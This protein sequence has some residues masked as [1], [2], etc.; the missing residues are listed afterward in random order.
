M[1]LF[2]ALAAAAAVPKPTELKLYKDWAV[3]CD[4]GLF[5]HAVGLMPDG[6]PEDAI[7]MAV[8][9]GAEPDARPVIQFVFETGQAAAL[10]ADGQRLNSRLI[11][12]DG[13]AR[14]D[15]A[16]QSAVIAALRSASRMDLLDTKGARIGSLSLAGASAALLFMDDRQHR[17]GTTSALARPG[18]A[19]AGTIP[20]PA[21]L[22]IVKA[23]PAARGHGLVLSAARVKALRKDRKCEIEDVGGPDEIESYKLDDRRSLLLLACGSGAYN[24]SSVV[25]I[26]EAQGG[27]IKILPAPF[28]GSQYGADEDSAVL[29]NAEWSATESLLS[30]FSKGRGLGDCATV[31]HYVWDGTRFRLVEQSEMS[32]C[33]GSTDYIRTWH[34]RV[35]GP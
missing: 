32:E 27:T 6:Q 12:E 25:L 11:V 35:I 18:A 20:A 29:T 17:I 22:P 5:C 34:A 3:G 13:G 24:L 30:S 1:I 21:P 28:D 7:T 15:P 33:R 14:V 23:A 9:R 4:N 8:E 16:D 2:L 10:M 19:P 31:Q 26:A